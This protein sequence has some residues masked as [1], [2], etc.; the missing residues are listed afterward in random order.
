MLTPDTIAPCGWPGCDVP[1]SVVAKA[2]GYSL[3]TTVARAALAD[4]D[5]AH[6]AAL[7]LSGTT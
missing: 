1:A 3:G 5:W 2:T 4:T 7:K 6:Y